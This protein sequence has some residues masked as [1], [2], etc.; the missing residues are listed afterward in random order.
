VRLNPFGPRSSEN[1]P[2]VSPA[3]AVTARARAAQARESADALRSARRAGHAAREAIT[4]TVAQNESDLDRALDAVSRFGESTL[5]LLAAELDAPDPITQWSTLGRSPVA[6]AGLPGWLRDRCLA[7]DAERVVLDWVT[8]ADVF[9]AH[10]EYSARPADDPLPQLYEALSLQPGF[11]PETAP[12]I[13]VE[14]VATAGREACE[15]IVRVAFALRA[16]QRAA[17]GRDIRSLGGY[18]AADAWHAFDRV[19]RFVTAGLAEWIVT[20]APDDELIAAEVVAGRFSTD[21]FTP[22]GRSTGIAPR[23]IDA[24]AFAADLRRSSGGRSDAGSRD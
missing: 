5:E 2:D 10:R 14:G 3:V 9:A 12:S 20:D 19:N 13:A 22:H 11:S 15:R 16:A 6:D 24:A 23:A 4:R 8:F 21:E 1:V 17:V 7:P 18:E